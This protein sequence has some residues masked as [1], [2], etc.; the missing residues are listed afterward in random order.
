MLTS[1][2]S[3]TVPL[4]PAENAF[5]LTF[6]GYLLSLFPWYRYNNRWRRRKS[7]NLEEMEAISGIWNF[8]IGAVDISILCIKVAGCPRITFRRAIYVTIYSHICNS[9]LLPFILPRIY[10]ILSNTKNRISCRADTKMPSTQLLNFSLS[11]IT[12]EY[13]F[14][15]H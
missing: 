3:G 12:Y 4:F 6:I 7:V 14:F 10:H 9:T 15:T 8:T 2:V 11:L 5:E 13:D 1:G